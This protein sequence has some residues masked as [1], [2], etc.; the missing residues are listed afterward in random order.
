MVKLF[1]IAISLLIF[2][3]PLSTHAE[4]NPP[5]VI[6]EKAAFAAGRTWVL[7][8]DGKLLAFAPGDTNVNETPLMG[9]GLT[10]C[11]DGKSLGV[12]TSNDNEKASWRFGWIRPGGTDVPLAI[13]TKGEKIAGLICHDQSRRVLRIGPMG[14]NETPLTQ[15]LVKTTIIFRPSAILETGG[16]ILI[17]TDAGEWGGT[18][19]A[20]AP[21]T[22]EVKTI[23]KVSGDGKASYSVGNI[24]GLIQNPWKPDCVFATVGLVHFG[25]QGEIVNVCGQ[26]ATTMFF[27]PYEIKGSTG[28]SVAF[29]GL[30]KVRDAVLAYGIDGLYRLTQNG[31]PALEP[32]PKLTP[33][34]PL[35]VS[36]DLPGVVALAGRSNGGMS[37]GVQVLTL[38]AR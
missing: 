25:P 23:K 37:I 26:T 4:G 1:R 17:G 9:R 7:T 29:Y 18:L 21:N 5:P 8:V 22:G 16:R 19:I 24:Q 14:L 10:I 38:V 6:I 13:K 12:I 31:K 36:Y 32:R 30:V 2:V 15:D 35:H 3:T 20:I 34:G 28:D 11:T 27:K 33:V